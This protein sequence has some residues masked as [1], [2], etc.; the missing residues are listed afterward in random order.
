MSGLV[1]GL[2]YGY[3]LL[4]PPPFFGFR[5]FYISEKCV[6]S[7]YSVLACDQSENVLFSFNHLCNFWFS[8]F[9]IPFLQLNIIHKHLDICNTLDHRMTMQIKSLTNDSSMQLISCRRECSYDVSSSGIMS[10]GTLSL[11]FMLILVRSFLGPT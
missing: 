7:L 11:E 5:F 3:G 8:L 2:C 10:M 6:V 4:L 9:I 1:G